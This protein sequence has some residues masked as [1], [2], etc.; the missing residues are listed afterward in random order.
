[1]FE[2]QER[3]LQ[4]HILSL[5]ERIMRAEK[6]GENPAHLKDTK[7]HAVR[8]LLHL[9]KAGSDRPTPLTDKR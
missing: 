4:A 3:E 6:Q 5:E 9:R 7:A 2:H 8:T 1:M